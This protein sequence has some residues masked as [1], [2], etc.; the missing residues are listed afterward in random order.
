MRYGDAVHSNDESDQIIM[1]RVMACEYILK[2][3]RTFRGTS[4]MLN[5]E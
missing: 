4:S 2:D 3:P 1:R 5:F